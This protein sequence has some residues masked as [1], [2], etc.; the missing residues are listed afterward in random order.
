MHLGVES[1]V[2]V[3]ADISVEDRKEEWSIIKGAI[4]GTTTTTVPEKRGRQK[5]NPFSKLTNY[6]TLTV[7]G[8]DRVPEKK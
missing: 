3:T 7:K 4:E 5:W 2:C 8:D 1:W 6:G